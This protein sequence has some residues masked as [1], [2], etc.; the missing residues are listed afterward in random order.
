MSQSLEPFTA[1]LILRDKGPELG[2]RMREEGYSLS[3]LQSLADILIYIHRSQVF[4]MLDIPPSPHVRLK[5]DD[6][7][8]DI[9]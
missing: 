9:G 7:Q 5:H 3:Q 1:Y 8:N 6:L 4:E 2:I